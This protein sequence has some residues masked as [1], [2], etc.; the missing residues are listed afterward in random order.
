[1]YDVRSPAEFFDGFEDTPGKEDRPLP[2]VFEELPVIVEG[3]LLAAE[4]IVIVDEIDLDPG[5]G[6][7]CY[8]NHKGPVDISDDYV[9]PGKPDYL[10]QLVLPFIDAAVS[11]HE[12]PDLL[13]ALL[14]TLWEETADF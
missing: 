7:G 5:C 9:H 3:Y 12:S 13:L 11:G 6:N 10:M 2:I 8:L 1:M 14:D 4:E